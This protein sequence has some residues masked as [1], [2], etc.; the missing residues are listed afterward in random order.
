MNW[1]I[2][3]LQDSFNK[4]QDQPTHVFWKC[5][6][7]NI[8]NLNPTKKMGFFM[9][10]LT[11]SLFFFFRTKTLGNCDNDIDKDFTSL[12][13][14]WRYTDRNTTGTAIYS[15]FVFQNNFFSNYFSNQNVSCTLNVFIKLNS[16]VIDLDEHTWWGWMKK[17]PLDWMIFLF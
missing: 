2:D 1:I 13:S 17:I 9:N 4:G 16:K 14:P 12:T 8:E 7:S 5:F 6:R 15:W 3:L 11:F 10:Y